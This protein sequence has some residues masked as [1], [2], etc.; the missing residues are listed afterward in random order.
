MATT[1]SAR[2][3]PS[4]T[5]S[6]AVA[7][8][9]G[10]PAI[11]PNGDL[12]II[13][14]QGASPSTVKVRIFK[15]IA[16]TS[17]GE[18]RWSISQT[19][20]LATPAAAT[21]PT[22]GANPSCSHPWICPIDDGFACFW[23]RR[24][25]TIAA[26]AM[27]I[28]GMQIEMA[29]LKAG[30]SPS[31]GYTK[32]ASATIGKG[33]VLD[34]TVIAGHAGGTPRCAW[35]RRN[36]VGVIFGSQLT[37]SQTVD[38]NQRTY[39]VRAAYLDFST[40]GK[41]TLLVGG[42]RMGGSADGEPTD[43]GFAAGSVA[44]AL[45]TGIDLDDDEDTP[46]FNAGGGLPHCIFDMRGDFAVCYE[47]R[48]GKAGTGGIVMRTFKGPGRGDGTEAGTG[49]NLAAI[50]TSTA[51][52]SATAGFAA[53][54]PVLAFRNVA[55]SGLALS[56]ANYPPIIITY[57]DQDPAGVTATKCLAKTITFPLNGAAPTIVALTV[58]TNTNYDATAEEQT[59]PF[60]VDSSFITSAILQENLAGTAGDG[61]KFK[62][63]HS[64][65]TGEI[66]FAALVEQPTRP[67]LQAMTLDD[68][69]KIAVLTYEG[70]DLAG[71]GSEQVFLEAWE[72]A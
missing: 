15:R 19:I 2:K 32:Y 64:D 54:R 25:T 48:N 60:A 72:F 40:D 22:A 59:L 53:R 16:D 13:Y 44:I 27:T 18:P 56:G 52:H 10:V 1:A 70:Q 47:V 65:G 49:M 55:R 3:L 63:I 7:S 43:G 31:S 41:P 57:G 17:Y 45:V 30:D 50:Y 39:A 21:T 36:Q 46:V 6:D 24:D 28:G 71:S 34:N 4:F 23:E 69:T 20:V 29:K 51:D 35:R 12:A 67:N 33:F 38:D 68:G 9:H 26:T 62:F 5:V 37:Y 58:P 11:H 8:T 14:H 66:R 42:N 61:R